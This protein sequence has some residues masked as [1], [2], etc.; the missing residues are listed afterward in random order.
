MIYI[1][2]EMWNKN[3]LKVSSESKNKQ[4][5]EDL[6]KDIEGVMFAGEEWKSKY[7]SDALYEYEPFCSDGFIYSV[8]YAGEEN[9]VKFAKMCL[10]KKI[11]KIAHLETCFKKE[12]EVKR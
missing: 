10:K 4:Y 7:N 3:T 6:M 11:E 5:I 9:F 1:D 2:L 12:C 8:Y